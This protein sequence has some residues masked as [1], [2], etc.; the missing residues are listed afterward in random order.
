MSAVKLNLEFQ[1]R[2][3]VV[4]CDY[5]PAEDEN[6]VVEDL[7]ITELDMEGHIMIGE[8]DGKLVNEFSIDHL[9][10]LSEAAWEKFAEFF[11]SDRIAKLERDNSPNPFGEWVR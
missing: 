5:Q 10:E 4:T 3:C 6:S 1:G 11:E 2:D 8:R 9:C 7:D